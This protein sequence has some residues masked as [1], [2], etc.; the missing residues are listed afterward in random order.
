MIPEELEGLISR[1]DEAEMT[2][3]ERA[4]LQNVL[5]E[6]PEAR[7]LLHQYQQLDKA[8][9]Q[10]PAVGEAAGESDVSVPEQL[11]NVD[12]DALH[13][14]ISRA[15][16]GIAVSD[17]GDTAGVATKPTADDTGESNAGLPVA[18]DW[19][20]TEGGAAGH[21][22]TEESGVAGPFQRML[23]FRRLRRF[24]LAASIAVAAL[25]GVAVWRY[26][27]PGT[28][29]PG[30][31]G[32]RIAQNN[33]STSSNTVDNNSS[34]GHETI[35]AVQLAPIPTLHRHRSNVQVML[36]S[37]NSAASSNRGSIARV[38]L[39]QSTEPTQTSDNGHEISSLV[40][41]S[42]SPK[43]NTG[44]HEDEAMTQQSND[45]DYMFF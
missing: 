20:M 29:V 11:E 24:S 35:E 42:A 26:S 40:V 30:G 9:S 15:I 44:R 16:D 34:A 18:G 7:E 4:Q 22:S 36:A 10:L 39:A 28:D 33:G 17:S 21:S 31:H 5:A 6:S 3:E 43:D 32:T 14:R 13:A 25:I 23:S 8:L 12:Y 19:R 41:C 45:S 37:I 1:Y 27:G 38:T 2:A